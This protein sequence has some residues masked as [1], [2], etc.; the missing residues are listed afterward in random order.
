MIG[1]GG[2]PGSVGSS[3]KKCR[4]QRSKVSQP[5]QFRLIYICTPDLNTNWGDSPH[6]HSKEVPVGPSCLWSQ[7]SHQVAVVGAD[8]E[9]IMFVLM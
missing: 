6:P 7:Y 2:T 1:L 3:V 5:A 4:G 8:V 9:Y